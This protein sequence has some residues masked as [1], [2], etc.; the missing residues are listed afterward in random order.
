MIQFSR[1]QFIGT[2]GAGMLTTSLRPSLAGES[3]VISIGSDR[4]LFVDHYL[5]DRLDGVRLQ[6]HRPRDEGP[7]LKFDQPWERLFCAYCTVIKDGTQ[8]RLYYRGCVGDKPNPDGSDA[9]TCVAVSNDGKNWTKPNLGLFEAA[10]TRQNNIV[11]SGSAH[12]THNFSPFID[13]RPGVPAE[14]RY[15]AIAGVGPSGLFSLASP[16]GLRWTLMQPGPVFTEKQALNLGSTPWTRGGAFDSQNV[17]FYSPREKCYLLYCRVFKGRLLDKDPEQSGVRRIARSTST[18][19]LNWTRPVLMEYGDQPLEQIYINQTHPYYR[20]P[21]IYVS[22]G[23]RL[24]IG[25]KV[26]SDADAKAIGVDPDYFHECSD[27]IF[28]TTRGGNR[29]DRTFMEGFL[30]PRLGLED[31]VSRTNFPALNVV[32]TR[33]DEMSLYANHNYGQPTAHIR[34]YSMRPDGFASVQAPFA[35]GE[36]LTKPFTFSGTKLTMNFASSAAGGIKV[37][38]QDASGKPLNG[39]S[40]ADTVETIGNDLNRTVR[41]KTGT[42]VM[43]LAGRP[44]RL[45]FVMKDADLYSIQFQ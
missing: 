43:S 14:E 44:V 28:M 10:G 30:R 37:E 35:G 36:L 17:A 41:W 1:R 38:I 31:W 3:N 20:A 29:Y 2:V 26:L 18:D 13:T 45:R 8:Y 22:L 21:H 6:L 32:E 24:M 16:D 23:A 12:L 25:R 5:I 34:R 42:N 19:F 11:Y 4:E 39:F 9:V 15:K 7:V 27:G 40:L 33:S